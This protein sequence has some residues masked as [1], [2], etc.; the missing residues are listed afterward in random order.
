M[1][2]LNPRIARFWERA[3]NHRAFLH[4]LLALVIVLT[5]AG[6]GVVAAQATI[7]TITI[8]SVAQNDS[9]TIRTHNFPANRSF[10]ARMGA[11]GTRGVNGT[12]VGTTNSGAGGT[13]DV[14]YD[15]PANLQG[16]RQ[17]AIRLE[18]SG[19]YYAFNWFWNSTAGPA[20]STPVATP[21]TPVPTPTPT[22]T[23]TTT[24]PT[25][26]ILSVARNDSVTIRTANFPANRDFTVRMGPMGTRG[27]NG[28]IVAT[29]NSGTG[30][31][32]DVTYDI[33]ANL[34]NSYQIAIRLESTSGG[35]FSYNWF[36]NNTTN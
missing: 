33:P 15:I 27:V 31:S 21:S 19:G 17:I 4:L 18:A 16:A 22:G 12:V 36:Y 28:T 20:P 10:T 13:F 26:Q 32:F 24:I 9:V 35:Y 23:R 5:V 30:G 29:T 11:M 3:R 7:P 6:S 34:H 25:F 1:S 2:S 14:T 8:V